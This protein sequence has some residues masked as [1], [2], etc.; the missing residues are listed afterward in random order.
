MSK[1]TIIYLSVLFVVLLAVYLIGNMTD[2]TVE[3]KTYLYDI[4]TT[5]VN[6]FHI[7]SPDNGEVT[8]ELVNDVW[9]VTSPV[10]FPA[11]EKN[12]H[13][14]L[15]KIS[16]LEIESVVTNRSEMQ[17]EYEVDSSGTF[18]EAKSGGKMSA[19]FI[20]GKVSSTYRHTYFRKSNSNQIYMIK[21]SFKF[22]MN[23]KLS[24]WRNKVILEI[25]K[26]AVESF[27]LTYP[28]EKITVTMEDTL[29]RADNVKE[30]F[31][32]TKKAVE[33]LLNYMARL[34]A[35]D[36]YDPEEGAEPLDFSKSDCVMEITFDGGKTQSLLLMKEN[37][38]GKKYYIKKADSDIVYMIYE[39]TAKILM[40]TMEDFRIQDKPAEKKAAPPPKM[41]K[42]LD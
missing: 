1:K 31:I 40:K 25:N 17:S 29:W 38:E 37:M 10:N 12:V 9:R 18:V 11:A 3:R 27:S 7:V 30:N 19:S 34:R 2:R 6:Y 42:K 41:P 4:D 15:N 32:A 14:L 39:G 21:G 20:M 28:K 35:S 8:M 23:R 33:P 36:F 5:K 13:E 26:D 16:E 22:Y 24:E